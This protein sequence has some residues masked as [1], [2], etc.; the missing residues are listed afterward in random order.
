MKKAYCLNNPDEGVRMASSSGGV[1]SM[2]AERVI[3]EGGVVYGAAFDAKWAVVH[4]RVENI[5]GISA[6]RGS[7]YVFSNFLGA[8]ND[9]MADLEA[10]R[11]VLFSGTPCQVAAMRKRADDNPRLLLAEVVCHGAPRPEYWARYLDEL[12][13]AKGK[14]L[15][16]ISAINF[17]DKRTGWRSYNF[18][19]T[20]KDGTDISE[21]HGKN[22]YMKGF[23]LNYTL[24]KACLSCP[25]K[26]PEGSKADVSLGDFWGINK[27]A[28]Q[29]Q[30]GCG[31][32]LVI[33]RTNRGI[34]SLSEIDKAVE[35]DFEEISRLH[36]ALTQSAKM[37]ARYDK[38]YMRLSNSKS[39]IDVLRAITRTPLKLQIKIFIASLLKINNRCE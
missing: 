4:R 37:P 2:L 9:A 21:H 1:F 6:L 39:I 26:Y 13:R 29:I 14:T 17:R 3:R 28:P 15:A 8:V 10:G 25:F 18:T 31:I 22:L 7:K 30:E 16:D 11:Q 5:G 12:C 23:L 19:V 38:A 20:F 34:D 35:F 27:L 24:R 33:A 32:S 36:P